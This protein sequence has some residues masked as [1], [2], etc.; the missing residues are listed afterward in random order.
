LLKPATEGKK[1]TLEVVFPMPSIAY[2]GT[3]EL[4]GFLSTRNSRVVGSSTGT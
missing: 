2:T 4:E 3:R 1:E